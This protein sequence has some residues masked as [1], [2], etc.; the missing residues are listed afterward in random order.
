M[1]KLKLLPELLDEL[2]C[3]RSDLTAEMMKCPDL[4]LEHYKRAVASYFCEKVIAS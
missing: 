3:A 1:K 4:T 2:E